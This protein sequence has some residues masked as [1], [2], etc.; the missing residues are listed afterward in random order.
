MLLAGFTC[1]VL[2]V[3]AGYVVLFTHL[4]TLLKIP[5][6]LLGLLWALMTWFAVRRLVRMRRG[7]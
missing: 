4:W 3:V 1:L 6:A 2:T 5:I 7:V